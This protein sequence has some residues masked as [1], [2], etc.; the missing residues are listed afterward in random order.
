MVQNYLQFAKAEDEYAKNPEIKRED[1]ESLQKWASK[2][3]HLPTIS[4]F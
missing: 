1:V 2:Q 4:G 3:P